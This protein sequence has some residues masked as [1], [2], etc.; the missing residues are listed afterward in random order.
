MIKSILV[1]GAT[2]QRGGATVQELLKFG[3]QVKA[4]IRNKNSPKARE[5]TKLGAELIEGDLL[6]FET[7]KTTL[8]EVD[9]VYMILPPVWDMNEE[10]D[11]KEADLGI[12]FIDLMKEKKIKFVIYSSVFMADKHKSFRPRFKHTIE[13]HLWKSGL[14]ATVLHPA[15]FM[16]NFL[17]PS[18]GITEG[19]LYNFMPQG[20]KVPYISTEDIGIFARIIFQNPDNYAGQTI[21]LLGDK[22]DEIEIL[23]ALQ[24]SLGINLE[25]V[26]LSLEELT[27]QNPLFG[28]LIEMFT[29]EPFLSVHLEALRILNPKLLSFSSWLEEFG[30]SKFI[31]QSLY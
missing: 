31:T 20:K 26:Q 30:K 9:A 11:N 24:T 6:N 7:F 27:A 16:E 3:F 14:K 22:I 29:Y 2:G 15:T 10:E 5:L 25:L 21:E 13:D 17:M 4:F 8:N 12:A 19:K 28:K 1:T 18:S 23:N